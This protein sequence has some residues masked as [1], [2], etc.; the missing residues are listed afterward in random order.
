MLLKKLHFKN[1][2]LADSEAP[3][4]PTQS[5]EFWLRTSHLNKLSLIGSR[6]LRRRQTN[7]DTMSLSKKNSKLGLW[8]WE[9]SELTTD[10][11]HLQSNWLPN[12][13]FILLI[14]K[15][16]LLSKT[17]HSPTNSSIANNRLVQVHVSPPSSH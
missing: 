17:L 9:R 10:M 5:W 16:I 6:F 14:C 2:W 8:T 4:L 3:H 11:F 15:V 1:K 13:I 7:I 12:L